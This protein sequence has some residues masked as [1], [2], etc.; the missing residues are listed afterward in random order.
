MLIQLQPNQQNNDAHMQQVTQVITSQDE[1]LSRLLAHWHIPTNEEKEQPT[2][3]FWTTSR[4]A[5]H[6]V[7]VR[8]L[9]CT[10]PANVLMSTY[11]FSTTAANIIHKCANQHYFISCR[12]LINSSRAASS[13]AKR[14]IALLPDGVEVRYTNIHAKTALIWNEKYHISVLF[15]ANAS[16][17][18]TI[19]RGMI[20][21]DFNTF[22]FDR[23][24]LTRLYNN[25]TI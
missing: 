7:I 9:Q 17:S 3:H 11:S 24:E 18:A 20:A 1:Y 23:N 12:I 2:F 13:Q 21:T 14:S 10:G 16:N 22:N 15:S 25:A 6:D 19:E 8:L 5:L 4:F